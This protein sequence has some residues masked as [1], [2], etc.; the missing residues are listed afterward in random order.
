MRGLW[1]QM[2]GSCSHTLG[3]CTIWG[4]P[5]AIFRASG[6]IWGISGARAIF[7]EN[8]Q[9]ILLLNFTECLIS[10]SLKPDIRINQMLDFSISV[11]SLEGT[12]EGEFVTFWQKGTKLY[13][14]IVLEIVILI[15]FSQIGLIRTF[16]WGT[17]WHT[18]GWKHFWPQTLTFVWPLIRGQSSI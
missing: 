3:F 1:Y 10:C 17:T 7:E 11:W 18:L 15:I 12:S 2:R 5:E 13:I 9:F 14:E 4:V 16:I 8:C 6:T